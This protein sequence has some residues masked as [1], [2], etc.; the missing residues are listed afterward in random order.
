MP[1]TNKSKLR[2]LQFV[3]YKKLSNRKFCDKISVSHIYF[4]KDGA[5]STDILNKIFSEYPELSME[6]VVTGRGEMF[7]KE[8]QKDTNM[9]N[10]KIL[11]ANFVQLVETFGLQ[12][13]KVLNYT[14]ADILNMKMGNLFLKDENYDG[15][16]DWMRNQG[17]DDDVVKKLD[18]EYIDPTA[19][20]NEK[21]TSD[22]NSMN[23]KL[24]KILQ[25]LHT[26][27]DEKNAPDIHDG[28]NG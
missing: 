9:I 5:I 11:T 27:I 15:L 4:T 19:R 26:Q 28:T 6:W 17:F 14:H 8:N 24:E 23:N 10:F 18:T 20:A 1:L 22:L 13:F 21:L 12:K 16:I 25:V 3:D 7:Y 2:V